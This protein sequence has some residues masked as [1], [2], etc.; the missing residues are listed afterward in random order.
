MVDELENGIADT[1]AGLLSGELPAVAEEANPS[2]PLGSISSEASSLAGEARALAEKIVA[3][4]L[5]SRR[6][7][8]ALDSGLPLPEFFLAELRSGIAELDSLKAL[9]FPTVVQIAVQTSSP[10][11]ALL[12]IASSVNEEVTALVPLM[13][14]ADVDETLKLV[15]EALPTLKSV[16]DITNNVIVCNDRYASLNPERIFDEYRAFEAPVLISK[17]DVAVNEKV[18]CEAWGLTP[19]NTDLTEPVV[20]NLPIMVSNGSMDGETP[21]EWGEAAAAGLENA[22]LVTFTYAQHGASTQF[23]C[24]PAVTNAF[25][26]YPDRQPVTACADDLRDRFPWVVPGASAP[27]SATE[28]LTGTTTI[29]GTIESNAGN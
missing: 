18:A 1:Y 20:S 24:G 21:V 14:D 25:F 29:T 2:N 22:F 5:E 12:G 26:M 3:L 15:Q 8:D 13:S 27:I 28:T 9:F 6:A 16:N 11:D 17:V 7:S 23:D 10:R 4:S 19:E